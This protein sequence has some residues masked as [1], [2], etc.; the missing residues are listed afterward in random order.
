MLLNEGRSFPL[1][2]SRMPR[3]VAHCSFR[4]DDLLVL[5]TDG[6]VERR[7]R[8]IDDG[9]EVLRDALVGLE[10][11]P[12]AA[13]VLVD[14][15]LGGAPQRDD[16]AILLNRLSPLH[17]VLRFEL[18]NSPAA[19]REIR[20]E[21]RDLLVGLGTSAEET[22]DVLLAVGEALTNALRY[23][24]GSVTMPISCDVVVRPDGQLV[25]TVRDHGKW[26]SRTEPRS[27]GGQ[28]LSIITRLM[29]SVE[30]D[31]RPDGTV[32]RVRHHLASVSVQELAASPRR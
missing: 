32:L 13:E 9:L 25:V 5:Y 1:G 18:T 3:P 8:S 24:P 17:T 6:L 26:L 27:E 11:G 12:G 16:I 21:L 23:A 22:S 10:W 4:A 29:D 31:R 30:I 7:G 14:R 15:C 28:G 2:V 19:L 20:A